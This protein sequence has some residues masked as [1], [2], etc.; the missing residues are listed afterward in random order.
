MA[1]IYRDSI[2]PSRMKWNG[3][4]TVHRRFKKAWN[5]NGMVY[6]KKLVFYQGDSYQESV[7][8]KRFLN[9][10]GVKWKEFIESPVEEEIEQVY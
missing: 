10:M 4:S 2:L 3:M 8:L 6:D 1:F 7:P 5:D 9:G